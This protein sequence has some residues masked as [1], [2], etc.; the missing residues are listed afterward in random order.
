[1]KSHVLAACSHIVEPE[2][3]DDVLSLG[4]VRDVTIAGGTARLTLRLPVPVYDHAEVLEHAIRQAILAVPGMSAAAI[5]VV[6]D[7]PPNSRIQS[8]LNMPVKHL[9]AVSSGKGGVGK[10]TIS[11]NL[12]VA[13]AQC[14]LSV[15]LMD[16]DILGPNI[17]MMMGVSSL[18][19]PA[20]QRLIPAEAFGV[21]VMSMGFLVDPNKPM[22]WRGPMVHAAIRQFFTDV[23]WGVLDYIII[24]LPPGTGDAQLTLAQSV[25]LSGAVVVTQPQNV[26]VGDALRGLE[27]FRQVNVPI[28]GVVENMSG[29]FFGSGGGLKL[30][31]ASGA[32]FLGSIPLDPEV[33]RGGD[34]GAPAVAA[35]A[36]SPA[37]RALVQAA[38][39]VAARVNQMM[40]DGAGSAPTI[41]IQ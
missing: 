10:S 36:E 9:V 14:G 31:Q 12:A 41:T 29:E 11:V 33:R 22:I 40:L 7:V 20:S 35:H 23:D 8:Q 6:R 25:P 18:P 38:L 19:S 37:A 21:K 13:L 32:A 28:L 17:P 34:S 27:M 5:D 15:G 39:R 1:M 2:T 30:A 4:L 24:D 26:A 16:A 3:G